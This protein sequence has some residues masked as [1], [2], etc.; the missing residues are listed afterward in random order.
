MSR[1]GASGSDRSASWC[2]TRVRVGQGGGHAGDYGVGAA[3]FGAPGL[4]PIMRGV[5]VKYQ[6]GALRGEPAGDGVAD[7]RAAAD[8]GDHRDPA[9]QWQ[10]I[11]AQLAGSEFG[12][13]HDRQSRA[14]RRFMSG[15]DSAVRFC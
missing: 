9:A 1:D 8:A 2:Q 10:R 13:S 6:A 15:V 12:K 11:P 3:G 14:G 5:V 7:A 4:V